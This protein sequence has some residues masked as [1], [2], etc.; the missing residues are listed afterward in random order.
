MFTQI[1][2]FVLDGRNL[3]PAK[4]R[5]VKLSWVNNFPARD[6]HFLIRLADELKLILSWDEYDEDDQNLTVLRLPISAIP[7]PSR[8]ENGDAK[9]DSSEEEVDGGEAGRA[10]VDRVLH[11]YSGVKTLEEQGDFDQRYD[12]ALRQRMDEWKQDYYRE[13]LHIDFNDKDQVRKLVYRYIEGLQWVMHYYYSGVASWGWFYDYHYAPRISGRS[14]LPIIGVVLMDS[15][16]LVEVDK[17]SFN[18]EL[19]KPFRP[20][21]QLMGVLPE[22]SRDLIP[23]AYQDLMTDP[24]SPILDFYPR[25]FELDLNGKKA[26]WEAIVKIP[27]IDQDRLLK[28]MGCKHL[29]T[30]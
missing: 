4:A 16:D 8:L 21:E 10:A 24:N 27:F 12:V 19:G 3:T 5:E 17:L 30:P 22:A 7:P 1:K 28:A 23:F 14:V 11:K 29:K 15:V 6:R 9:E 20:F 25:E 13:K 2:K 18:F 26:D